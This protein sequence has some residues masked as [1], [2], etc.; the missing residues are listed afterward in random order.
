MKRNLS[1]LWF[2]LLFVVVAAFG[3]L[4]VI[5]RTDTNAQDAL[6]AHASVLFSE[7]RT[8]SLGGATIWSLSLSDWS[9]K[10]IA[11]LNGQGLKVDVPNGFF[12]SNFFSTS[13]DTTRYDTQGNMVEQFPGHRLLTWKK[14]NGIEVYISLTGEQNSTV[15]TLSV[16]AG[17]L[18]HE[19]HLADLG[20]PDGWALAD[21]WILDNDTII[22]NAKQNTHDIYTEVH[23]TKITLSTGK[24][25][26]LL[27]GPA[28]HSIP[29]D[30]S[31][32]GK[33]V[34]VL[35]NQT[36]NTGTEVLEYDLLTKKSTVVFQSEK[37]WESL[38]PSSFARNTFGW[39][40]RLEQTINVFR[41][42]T[43]TVTEY[44]GYQFIGWLDARHAFVKK[45]TEYQYLDLDTGQSAAV[46]KLQKFMK[47][48]PLLFF[49]AV[50]PNIE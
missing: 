40:M 16:L 15:N 28:K 20:I 50:I 4:F 8:P 11:T 36:A 30:F 25:E 27:D 38:Y 12:F 39:N 2:A 7:S 22:V 31:S 37:T 44:P 34:Y 9:A 46:P 1:I 13:G 6:G 43:K 14:Q 24:I 3:V 41:I 45:D 33:K 49:D 48:H 32:D 35:Q 29:L 21:A 47:D 26:K 23:L 10:N 17:G 42:S 5:R 19:W 18:S